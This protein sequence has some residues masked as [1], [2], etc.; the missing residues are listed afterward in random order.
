[1]RLASDRAGRRKAGKRIEPPHLAEEVD[2]WIWRLNTEMLVFSGYAM[3]ATEGG[4]VAN[5]ALQLNRCDFMVTVNEMPKVSGVGL[6]K[7]ADAAHPRQ[8]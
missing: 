1:M 7:K 2:R 4:S 8:Q 3:D 5:D 6:L